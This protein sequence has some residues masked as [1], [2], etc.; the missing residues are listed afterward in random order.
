MTSSMRF[1]KYEGLGNDFIVID[2]DALP[3][4]AAPEQVAQAL[5]DRHFGIGAD[6]VLVLSPSERARARMVIYNADGSRPEMCGNGL[7][8]VAAHL[9]SGQGQVIVDTDAGLYDCRVR[10]V[11]GATQVEVR[12][13]RVS[14]E[15]E[16]AGVDPKRL[17][18]SGSLVLEVE[19]ERLSFEVA[20]TGNPHA[21]C[22]VDDP[23][24]DLMEAASRAG[25]HVSAHEAFRHGVNAA[26]GRVEG[27]EVSLVV[28]ER[29]AGLT[30]ACGTGACAAVGMLT[31]LG[32]VE[33]GSWTR[34]HLPGGPLDIEVTEGPTPGSTGE[35]IMRGPA[36]RVFDGTLRHPGLR[37]RG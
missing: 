25:P 11:E 34:V 3:E 21:L 13:G 5:C 14:F 20:S 35:V 37:I 29:G 24:V 12:M 10:Q 32:R 28:F 16:L 19:G 22:V 4:G 26:W 2:A 6:G 9:I 27:G 17:S 7:R 18:A 1:S 36:R 15:P 31:R 33:V 8:C 23:G 30:L